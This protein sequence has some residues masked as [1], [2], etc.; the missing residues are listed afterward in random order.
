MFA[1]MFNWTYFWWVLAVIVFI[2]DVIAIIE[3]ILS[4]RPLLHKV[5]WVLL[6]LIFPVL[7]LLI[8]V[9]FD[10]KSSQII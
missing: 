9:I 1:K 10:R 7:G 2:A 5:A 8:Y 3:V 6:I 4:G